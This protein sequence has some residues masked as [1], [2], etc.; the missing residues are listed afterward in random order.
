MMQP[1]QPSSM[2]ALFAQ[3]GLSA[4]DAYTF[5]AAIGAFFTVVLV[6]RALMPKTVS[7]RIHVIEERRQT[8]KQEVTA[9]RKRRRKVNEDTLNFIRLVVK[10]LQLLKKGQTRELSKF[11]ISAGIRHPDAV[12]IFAFAQLACPILFFGVSLLLIDIGQILSGEIT[13]K[14][15]IPLVAL[16]IG[17]KAPSLF[18]KNRRDKRYVLIQR[19]LAD[20]LDLL[21]ICAEA[22]LSLAQSLDRVAKELQH[23]YPEMA[24]E[25][26]ITSIELSFQPD[27]QK[28]LSGLAQRVQLQEVK[29]IVNVLIQ[30]EKYGTPIAQAL[31]TLSA[32]F[33]TQRM[34]RA[35]QKAAR[36]PA[37]MTV[38]M[39]IFILPTLFIVVMA[40]AIIGLMDT[41]AN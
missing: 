27:R 12:M 18:V 23:A 35:E 31:R 33:R 1:G 32:E 21:M 17:T 9:P 24:E 7:A 3:V 4:Q 40:P 39:I 28:T 14:A 41:T 37:I 22:G 8:L 30:T 20:T 2:N 11:L 36:L 6:G 25:L 26:S 13:W 10:K 5:L 38:P 19:S 16:F 15:F 29:G 34:L